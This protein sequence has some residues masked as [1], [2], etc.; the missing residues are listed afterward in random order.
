MFYT[1]YNFVLF[2]QVDI[3]YN[4]LLIFTFFG[5][6]HICNDFYLKFYFIVGDKVLKNTVSKFSF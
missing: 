1:E 5:L 2:T 3:T 4:C 6:I